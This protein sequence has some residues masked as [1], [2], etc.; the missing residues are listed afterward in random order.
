MKESNSKVIERNSY[1][2]CDHTISVDA[3]GV[4]IYTFS[5]RHSNKDELPT[6]LYIE[7]H[8]RVD[9]KEEPELIQSY[10][11]TNIEAVPESVLVEVAGALGYDGFGDFRDVFANEFEA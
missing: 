10:P 2:I 9:G 11:D 6:G 5:I 7:R 4:E 1:D 3:K 8:E